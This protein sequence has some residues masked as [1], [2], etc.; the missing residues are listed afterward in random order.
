MLER[1]AG[2]KVLYLVLS[3]TFLVLAYSQKC[4]ALCGA[5][6]PTQRQ[7][8]CK[9]GGCSKALHLVRNTAMDDSIGGS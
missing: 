5:G 6:N 3:V 2:R 4:V 8:V 7:Y 9:V 1:S